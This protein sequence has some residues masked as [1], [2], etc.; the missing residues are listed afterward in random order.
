MILI[1]AFSLRQ[2]PT[3]SLVLL[4]HATISHLGAYAHCCKHVPL[5]HQIPVYATEPVI[6]L[7]RTLTQDLYTSTPLAASLLPQAAITDTTYALSGS[8]PSDKS[9]ILLPAPSSEEIAG[10]FSRINSLRYSQVHQP[11]VSPFSPPLD[12]LTIAAY[13]AGHTL[14][15]TIWHIQ[16]GSES[17]V[18]AVDWNQARENALPGAAW[19][20]RSGATGAEII[21]QL[22]RPTAL[23]CSSKGAG[24][25]AAAGGLKRRDEL[26]LEQIRS[27]IKAGG[28]VLIP[29]DSS[30]RALELSYTLER[31]WNA[32]SKS[33]QDSVLQKAKLYMASSTAESTM[34]EARRMLEW[35]DESI[36]AEFEAHSGKQQQGQDAQKDGQPQ[37][38]MPFVFKHLK[39]LERQSQVNRALAADSS[40]VFIASDNSLEWG[41]SRTILQHITDDDKNMILLVNPI[42]IERHSANQV[43]KLLD[44]ISGFMRMENEDNHDQKDVLSYQC[45]GDKIELREIHT[46]ALSGN[47][48][49]IYQQYLAQQRQRQTT[50]TSDGTRNTETA[51]DAVDGQS[52]SSSSSDEDSD[53]EHQGK[54]LN[55]SAALAHSKHKVELTDEDLGV[56]ILLRRKDVYDYDVRGKK[57]RDRMFPYI[58]KKRRLDDFGEVIKPEDYLR[59]EERD[60]IDGQD[61]AKDQSKEET[62]VGHKRKWDERDNQRPGARRRTS[63]STNKRRKTDGD[64]SSGNVNDKADDDALDDGDSE[65]SDYEPEEPM[66]RGPLRANF[67][68]QTLQLNLKITAIDFFGI[69]DRRTLNMLMPLIRPRKLILTGGTEAETLSLAEDCRKLLNSSDNSNAKA[70]A[71]DVITPT[72]GTSVDASV[73]TNAWTIKLTQSLFKRLRWQN[74]RGLGIVTVNG[75]LELAPTVEDG[76]SGKRQ[77][78]DQEDGTSSAASKS[79][80][81]GASQASA[82]PILTELLE[83][84]SLSRP[85]SDAIHV[86]D[87]RLAELR[88]IMQASGHTAEFKGEGTLLVDGIVAV[89]KSGIGKIEV[90]SGGSRGLASGVSFHDVK[91]RIYEGLAVVAAR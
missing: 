3:I 60:E 1:H 40:K 76:T 2:V 42:S 69:H 8:E 53:A 9:H 38:G 73:D 44:N 48:L 86:G 4:T 14:G 6:S 43:P 13:C 55:V 15:G 19:L 33:K 45:N 58:P 10:Y 21:E 68:T 36:V 35:M 18:Y 34:K 37:A 70:T 71:A 79:L 23:I 16:H 91:R 59:A 90:E 52:D 84:T 80:V 39:T 75:R 29:T 66:L 24:I 72:I 5:F 20:G 28:S 46:S 50:F 87:L 78:I 17:V 81:K 31:A 54:V 62:A 74:F 30:A 7:G 26:L 63:M 22:R 32:E 61:M 47:D 57:G 49:L 82:L 41:F 77:K 11:I 51:I 88:R 56:N 83:G 89:R 65:E 27:T 25:V 67:E 85:V 64:P 12:G